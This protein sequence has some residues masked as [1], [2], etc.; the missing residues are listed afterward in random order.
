MD[1]TFCICLGFLAFRDNQ[2]GGLIF[3]PF[4]LFNRSHA[5]DTTFCMCNGLGVGFSTVHVEHWAL[6]CSTLQSFIYNGNTE[7][8]IGFLGIRDNQWTHLFFSLKPPHISSCPV[9]W[10]FYS[11]CSSLLR[12][13]LCRNGLQQCVSRIWAWILEAVEG[14]AA[15]RMFWMMESGSPWK[16]LLC[17]NMDM[18]TTMM[19]VTVF[20]TFTLHSYFFESFIPCLIIQNVTCIYSQICSIRSNPLN[21]S[22]Q[23][24]V[25]KFEL[26][27]GLLIGGPVQRTSTL[28]NGPWTSS[29]QYW[30]RHFGHLRKSPSW[31]DT[32][33]ISTFCWKLMWT[34]QEMH[35][36]R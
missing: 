16:A 36:N 10:E 4:Q 23:S 17:A 14:I 25:M 18:A 26:G 13:K 1:T 28:A 34:K 6:N 19:T 30:R 3:D 15:L 7:Y 35:R 27:E 2:C 24:I 22:N 20:R 31:R 8:A 12:L 29:M 11:P 21:S 9:L 32:S 5:M 33:T